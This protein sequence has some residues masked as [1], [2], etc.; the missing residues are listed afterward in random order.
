MVTNAT[1]IIT[2]TITISI[3]IITNIA[4]NIITNI[5]INVVIVVIAI[6]ISVVITIA[7][8]I[9]I[10]A[11]NIT[12]TMVLMCMLTFSSCSDL[13]ERT[14]PADGTTSDMGDSARTG[15]ARR[16]HNTRAMGD[17]AASPSWKTISGLQAC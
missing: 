12:I 10:T 7:T 3:T 9:A 1:I 17:A 5:I 14:A 4:I 11:T 8:A 6:T 2:I 16:R 13:L 15:R